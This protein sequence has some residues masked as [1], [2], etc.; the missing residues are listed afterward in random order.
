MD[1][2]T[3]V[4]SAADLLAVRPGTGAAYQALFLAV[5][6][7]VLGRALTMDAAGGPMQL[8]VTDVVSLLD[9]LQLMHGRLDVRLAMTGI[10]WG[11]RDFGHADVV[12][13]NTQLRPGTPPVVVAGPV[14][15]SLHVPGETLGALLS[16]ARPGMSGHIDDEGVARLHWARRP[17]WGNVVVDIERFGADTMSALRITPR[18]LAVAGRHWNLPVRTQSYVVELTALPPDVR[19]TAVQVEP[20]ALR[21]DAV[22][23]E[24]QMPH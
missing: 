23:P 16:Q 21:V 6:R 20:G 10:D 1:V 4:W 19:L 7:V 9:P 24:W 13:R 17:E 22:V 11:G 14:E 18:K 2:M 15:V 8:T 3:A 5:R 12:L